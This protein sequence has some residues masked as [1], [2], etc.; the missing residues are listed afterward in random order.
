MTSS[1]LLIYIV[2]A[3]YMLLAAFKPYIKYFRRSLSLLL[4][5]RRRKGPIFPYIL[6]RD[7]CRHSKLVQYV[8]T[9]ELA[10]RIL[11]ACGTQEDVVYSFDVIYLDQAYPLVSQ[12]P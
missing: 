9:D 5:F 11:C 4:L 1:L 7:L 3:S 12:A 10:S 8:D 2:Y 6:L